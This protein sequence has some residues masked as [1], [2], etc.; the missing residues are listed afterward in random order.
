MNQQPDPL[1]D[2]A[3]PSKPSTDRPEVLKV[4][5][6][7]GFWEGALA[8][9][10]APEVV[11]SRVVAEEET[12]VGVTLFGRPRHTVRRQVVEQRPYQPTEDEARMNDEMLKAIDA[13]RRAAVAGRDLTALPA[14]YRWLGRGAPA[15]PAASEE[16]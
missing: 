16:C 14:Y 10:Q 1:L 3:R 15:T 6:F 11:T 9:R 2:I 8:T 4:Y 13:C 5:L 7:P 12:S